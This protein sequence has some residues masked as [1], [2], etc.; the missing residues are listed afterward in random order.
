MTGIIKSTYKESVKEYIMDRIFR[1]EYRPGEKVTELGVARTLGVS[2]AVVREAFAELKGRKVLE[3]I[4]YKETRI[5]EISLKEI[6]D[7]L[8]VRMELEELAFRWILGRDTDLSCLIQ[9]LERI[10]QEMRNCIPGKESFQ[11]REK[12][13]AFHR[14]IFEESEND[15]LLDLWDQLG[16]VGWIYMGLYW[17][18]ENLIEEMESIEFQ[19]IC[20]GYQDIIESFRE[21]DPEKFT[22]VIR[23]LTLKVF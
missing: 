8:K 2:Q 7:A 1:G 16:D 14:R 3:I 12:D 18:F 19:G 22:S 15:T 5:R 23:G 20:D 13:I 10:L 4:P 6:Q 17:P 21:K 9:D 11:Y